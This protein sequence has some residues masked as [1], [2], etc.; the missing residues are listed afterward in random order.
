MCHNK[1][2]ILS[3]CKEDL[4]WINRLSHKLFLDMTMRQ[5]LSQYLNMIL[6]RS[7]YVLSFFYLFTNIYVFTKMMRRRKGKLCPIILKCVRWICIAN[8]FLGIK[9]ARPHPKLYHVWHVDMR[10]GVHVCLSVCYWKREQE[11]LL[12]W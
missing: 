7:R 10:V 12:L 11:G 4:F 8:Y 1:H 3:K 9:N 6:P 2:F 5:G